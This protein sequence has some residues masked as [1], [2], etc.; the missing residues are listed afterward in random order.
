MFGD[1]VEGLGG[2][3]EETGQ[4]AD[5]EEMSVP[6]WEGEGRLRGGGTV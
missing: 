4:R 6:V 3:G 1:A 5:E 2:E